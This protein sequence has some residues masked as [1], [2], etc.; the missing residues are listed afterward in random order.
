MEH[1]ETPAIEVT[2]AVTLKVGDGNY[3][4]YQA[5]Q[6]AL[7]AE[8][9]DAIALLNSV[10]DSVEAVVVKRAAKIVKIAGKK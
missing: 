2:V 3:H 7:V 10:M 1:I 9:Q 8:G 5:T 4:K 6:Q